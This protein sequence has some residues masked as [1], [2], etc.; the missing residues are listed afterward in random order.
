MITQMLLDWFSSLFAGIVG[1]IPPFNT[2]TR[3]A[4]EFIDEG[5]DEAV[6]A[7]S[8]FGILVPFDAI[9]TLIGLWLAAIGFW[10]ITVVVRIVFWVAGR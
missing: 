8:N 1:L 5:I 4:V 7:V 6:S 3:L 10:A 2:D 9:N